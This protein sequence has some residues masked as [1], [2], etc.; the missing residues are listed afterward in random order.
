MFRL[1]IYAKHCLQN[2]RI[3]AIIKKIYLKQKYPENST[4]QNNEYL[5]RSEKTLKNKCEKD[6]Q[7]HSC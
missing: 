6:Q 7:K 5:E 2:N 4:I 1:K 3:T